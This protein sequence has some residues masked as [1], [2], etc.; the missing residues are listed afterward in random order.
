MAQSESTLK[1]NADIS[2]LKKGLADANRQIRL[3]NAQFSAASSAMDDWSNSADGLTKKISQLETVQ[4]AEK[5]KLEL[6]N[7]QYDLTVKQL[8]ATS[9]EAQ[10]LEIQINRQ[11]TTINKVTSE[12]NS[13]RSQLENVQNTTTQTISTYDKLSAEISSQESELKRLQRQYAN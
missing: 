12:L 11:Q 6:L 8:G 4:D 3:A 5:Q 10:E 2:G 9:K 13:Y 7:K 1:F